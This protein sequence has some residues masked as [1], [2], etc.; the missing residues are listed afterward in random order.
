MTDAAAGAAL[1]DHAAEAARVAAAWGWADAELRPVSG[2]LIN[3]TFAVERGGVTVAALQRLHPVF[4]PEVNLD[5]DAVTSYLAAKGVY[6]PRL[7][8]TTGGASWVREGDATWRAMSW[9]AGVTVHTVPSP[10]WAESGGELVG[11]FHQALADF[12]HDYAFARAGVHD[13]D[14]HLARLTAV[15]DGR[16]TQDARDDQLGP[17][18]GGSGQWSGAALLEKAEALG[19]EILAAARELP[20]LPA[21][22][23]RRHCHGDLKISNL[24]FQE[25]PPVARCL[26][27]LD[28]IGLGTIAFE[29]GDAMRSWCNPRGEDAGAVRFDLVVF[30]AAMRGYRDAVRGLLGRD[31]LASIAIGLERVCVEL[32]ARFCVDIFEDRYFGWDPTRFASRP[33]HNLVRARAQLELAQAVTESRQA[34]LDALL[35]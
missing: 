27:D 13:T 11:R 24:L 7:L 25:S 26:V 9:A 1:P 14:A 34:A 20:P 12:H 17:A 19:H 2:G 28:T 15:L 22:L 32:A 29:L 35:G 30:A 8:R 23:P 21:D 33:A 4:A 6:T 16:P 3:T 5:I 18:A 10:A 31:E